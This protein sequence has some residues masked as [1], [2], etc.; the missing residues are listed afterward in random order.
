MIIRAVDITAKKFSKLSSKALQKMKLPVNFVSKIDKLFNFEDAKSTKNQSKYSLDRSNAFYSMLMRSNR[1]IKCCDE[2]LIR[3]YSAG[4]MDCGN[5][6]L[7]PFNEVFF[8]KQN[9][10]LCL[11]ENKHH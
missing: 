4:K 10:Q 1:K 2:K 7:G 11:A 6:Q 8:Q 9:I 5:S 3:V